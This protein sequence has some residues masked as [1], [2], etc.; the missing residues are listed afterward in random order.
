MIAPDRMEPKKV[1]HNKT[2]G[3]DKF[4]LLM[5][6]NW[7][8][9]K[10]HKLQILV[11]IVLPVI[12]A[13][14]LVIIRALIKTEDYPEITHYEPFTIGPKL[15]HIPRFDFQVNMAAQLPSLL[16]LSSTLFCFILFH[17]RIRMKLMHRFCHGLWLGRPRS[18]S[19]KNSCRNWPNE[20][21]ST[22]RITVSILKRRW[23]TTLSGTTLICW[24]TSSV[25]SSSL[26]HS[27]IMTLSLKIS[28]Y[29]V[30]LNLLGQWVGCSRLCTTAM[31]ALIRLFIY[32][33]LSLQAEKLA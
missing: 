31:A 25:G 15:P 22:W 19:S 13:S 23:S 20:P 32:M 14:L 7:T 3:W 8:S 10:R 2:T 12:F 4:L 5:W 27:P 6:K 21:M 16:W 33:L 29:G 9:Q 24:P 30:R 28:R 26:T 18:Q 11:E 1:V 17:R